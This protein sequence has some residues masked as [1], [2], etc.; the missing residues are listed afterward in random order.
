MTRFGECDAN[1][2]KSHD[3]TQA[4]VGCH[5]PRVNTLVIGDVGARQMRRWSQ[6][7]CNS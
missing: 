3:L 2:V 1:A 4:V 7:Y 6:M 5:Q